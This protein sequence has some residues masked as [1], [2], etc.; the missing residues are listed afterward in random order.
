MKGAITLGFATFFALWSSGQRP[1]VVRGW[2]LTAFCLG[3]LV[4]YALIRLD[5]HRTLA[6]LRQG[7]IR[8]ALWR[9]R[10]RIVNEGGPFRRL[11]VYETSVG[12]DYPLSS[13]GRVEIWFLL[14]LI[15]V[16]TVLVIVMPSTPSPGAHHVR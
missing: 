6:L 14:V 1:G 4:A 15:V 5:R 8:Q 9:R 12:E 2:T 13:E 7:R 11:L 16:G 10:Y 3:G